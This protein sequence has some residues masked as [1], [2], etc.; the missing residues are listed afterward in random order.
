MMQP[1]APLRRIDFVEYAGVRALSNSRDGVTTGS[2]IMPQKKN[3]DAA[4]LIR[5]RVGRVYGAPIG[6]AYDD[7]KRCRSRY[8]RDM[9]EDKVHL[10]SG[11]DTVLLRVHLTELMFKNIKW[12]TEAMSAALA[13]D[14]SNATDLADD[15]VEKG[16]SFRE[17]HHI[18]GQLVQKCLSQ[19]KALEKLTVAELRAHHPAFDESSLRKL[20]HRA[21]M[22]ARTSAGGTA[23]SSVARQITAAEQLC[24]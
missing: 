16:V 11:I 18:V 19:G 17:A 21:V 9:Q 6:R 13:G 22:N 23:P 8:N 4:E 15:L 7:E 2:S 14:F 12:K 5:G 20:D 1:S 3:P 10:F 24:D